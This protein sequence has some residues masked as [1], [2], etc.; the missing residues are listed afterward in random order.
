MHLEWPEQSSELS[1]PGVLGTALADQM[2]QKVV[3]QGQ[4]GRGGSLRSREEPR[5]FGADV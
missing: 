3:S 2:Q 5:V 4:R 1:L